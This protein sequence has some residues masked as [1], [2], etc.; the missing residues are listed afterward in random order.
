MTHL[1]GHLFGFEVLSITKPFIISALMVYFL[2]STTSRSSLFYLTLAALLMSWL[3]DMFLMFDDQNATFFIYGLV[4]F[5]L[6]HVI[7][8]F[9]YRKAKNDTASNPLLSSQ[10]LRHGSTL[11]LAG[12]ALIYVLEPGLG[13]MKIPVMVYASVIVVM[14]ITALLRYGYSS[15]QSFSLVFGGAIMFMISDSLLA[16]NKFLNPFA[17]AGFWIMATYCLAQF[18]IVKG[19]INHLNTKKGA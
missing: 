12:I 18:L 13:E 16:V 8:I 6:A 15:I 11:V 14:T 7:Y 19:I 10:K 1:S 3:G 5:L 17:Y 2:F 4:S 9:S